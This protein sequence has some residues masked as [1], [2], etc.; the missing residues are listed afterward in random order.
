MGLQRTNVRIRLA[1][2]EKKHAL[3]RTMNGSQIEQGR[4]MPTF[5]TTV[6]SQTSEG[7]T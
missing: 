7:E 4:D 6:A 3:F 5:A 2:A 1:T